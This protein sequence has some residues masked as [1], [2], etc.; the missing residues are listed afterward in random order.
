MLTTCL[1]TPPEKRSFFEISGLSYLQQH[2]HMQ[3]N[4]F[5]SPIKMSK[6]GQMMAAQPALNISRAW[7][8]KVTPMSRMKRGTMK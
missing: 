8:K 5:C 1:K 3:L 2:L 6:L 4:S 7:S